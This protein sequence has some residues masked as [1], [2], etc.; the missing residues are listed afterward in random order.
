VQLAGCVKRRLLHAMRN[1]V[2]GSAEQQQQLMY[3]SP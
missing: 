2:P 1:S 3:S